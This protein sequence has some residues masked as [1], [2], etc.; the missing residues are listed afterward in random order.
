MCI[1]RNFCLIVIFIFGQHLSFAGETYKKILKRGKIHCG[2]S[3]GV[4]GFSYV[5]NKGRWKGID[6]RICRALAV[7]IFNDTTKVL[8]TPLSTQ[9][10]FTSLQ[11]GEI[12]L[13]SRNTTRTLRRDVALKLHFAPVVYYD[14]QAFMVRKKDKIT[15]IKDLSGASFCIQQGTTTEVNT[16]DYFRF[17][18]MKL[19]TV[20]FESQE[21]VLNAFIKGRCDVITTDYSGLASYFL[22]FKNPEKYMI[23]PNIISKEPLSP[24]VNQGD[25]LWA[26]IV[27]WSIY[28]LINAEELG[29]TSKNISRMMKSKD[30]KIQRFLGII[31][32]NG[33]HFGLRESWAKD[34]VEK[35]GNYGE[36]FE[37]EVGSKS[38]LKLKRGLNELWTNGGLHYAPP[39]K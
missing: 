8:F 12:D 7:A 22:K 27:T 9:Q 39:M 13:L 5:D 4:P 35:V 18:K 29:I 25:A 28:A 3:Q 37:E 2:V 26:D 32:G 38:R 34:I 14:G 20:N 15:D 24:V 36:I 11:S 17:H 23:L 1:N 30:P 10:R 16:A 31:K 19:K 33:A 6:V 21:E